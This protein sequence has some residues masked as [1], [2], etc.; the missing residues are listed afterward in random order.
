MKK[1]YFLLFTC[2]LTAISFAQTSDLYFS[3]YGEGSS[4]NKFLEIYN[5]TG[6][7]VNLDDYAFPNVSND[8][9]VVGEYEFWNTF[10]SGFILADG[11]VFVIAHGSAD[12][13]ILAAADMT[14]NFLSNGDDGFALVAN[15]GTWNDANTNGTVDAGE[16]TGFT[17]LDWLGDFDGDPG[18]GWDVAGVTAA[19][20]NHT[21]TRK[22]S[23]C[24]PNNDWA[25]SAG[26]DANDSE[27]I[28]TDIDSGW[29]NLGSYVGCSSDP[30]LTIT[31]PVDG[32][33]F[34]SGTTNVDV[35]I[36]VQNFVIGNPGAGIDGHIHWTLNGVSQPMKYNTDPE[37]I[38]VVDGES[39][40]VFMQLVDN[41]H[42]PI[43]PAVEQTVTFSVEFPCDLQVGTITTTCDTETAGVD[44]YTVSIEYTGG[45]TSTYII[46][47]EGFGSVGGDDPSSVTDGTITITGVDEG[48]N[49]TITFTGDISDSSCDFTR[50]ITSPACVG[51]VVC[52]SYGD[53][54]IT[55]IMQNPNVV[56]DSEGEW[57]EVYNTTGAP[58]NMQG[59]II[60]DDASAGEEFVIS[61]LIVPANGYA[62]FGINAD[63]GTNGGV[64]VDYEYA[65]ISL[66]N[67]ADGL[68]I[69]CSGTMI[70]TVIWDGGTDFPDPT[71]ISMELSLTAFNADD[72]DIGANWGEGSSPFG[73]GDLGTPGSA[74]DFTLSVD[75]F[76]A[77]QFN[78][79]PNPVTNGFVNITS[80]DNN[81]IS[82][83]IFDILGK[84]VI[85]TNV[86][87]KRVDVSSLKTGI[88]M[89]RISQNG[90]S[91]TKK[92]VIK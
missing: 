21:L 44:T 7:D 86:S 50:S 6:S 71:G 23:V 24:G 53:I 79:Y 56:N 69:E 57:F 1:I 92:L 11:D 66:G 25:S 85:N 90:N 80:T 20:A 42:T 54:I 74:N 51:G 91:I 31:S 67:G 60:K 89:M 40:T 33:A 59:W 55:E 83:A 48:T 19:T 4:N 5:G 35:S 45:G 46:D 13:T 30:V 84:Q 49:F 15:D 38:T 3:M 65:G 16:M 61:A 81:D 58:I 75:S 29:D 14:F 72:N 88:Y 43:M 64:P 68:I 73:G 28:V 27:W 9:T 32:T 47:T 77:A 62:V 2:L 52:G 18:S 8:P 37:S 76:N 34:A 10:P 63:M 87:N 82:V 22:T 12:A 39:Y 17:V 36:D 26:T 70:D 78:V 41:S